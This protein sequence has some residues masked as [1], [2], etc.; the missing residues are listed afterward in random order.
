MADSE[1]DATTARDEETVL[2]SPAG[3]TP[4]T[5]AELAARLANLEVME[6]LGQGGMGIVYKGRRPLLDRIVAIKV[7][8]PDLETDDDLRERFLREARTLAKL[9]HPFIVTVFDV[10]KAGDVYGL[11]MEY[12]EGTSLRQL[13]VD[14]SITQSR[15][16]RLRAPDH[17]GPPARPRGRDRPPGHQARKRPGEL[18]GGCGWWISAWPRSSAPRR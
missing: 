9:R 1:A 8:R 11:V 16:P 2:H 17:R 10:C 3:Y 18:A 12:V 13:L 4:P 6:L 14:G 7:I 5:P 15:C